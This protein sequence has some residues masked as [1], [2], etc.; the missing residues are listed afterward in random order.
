MFFYSPQ[1]WTENGACCCTGCL[2][3]KKKTEPGFEQTK[4]GAM[5]LSALVVQIYLCQVNQIMWR[6]RDNLFDLF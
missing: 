1:T 2:H 4:T 3:Q 5:K 6:E